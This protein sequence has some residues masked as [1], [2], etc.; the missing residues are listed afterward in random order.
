MN[1][2]ANLVQME[3]FVLMWLLDINAIVLEDTMDL[4]A[5]PM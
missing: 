1:V 3:V 4:D 2:R 5:N